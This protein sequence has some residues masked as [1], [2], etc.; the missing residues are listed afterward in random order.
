M[1][2]PQFQNLLLLSGNTDTVDDFALWYAL[3]LLNEKKRMGEARALQ[4]VR[5]I[6]ADLE[7]MRALCKRQIASLQEM[8]KQALIEEFETLNLP[9]IEV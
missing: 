5:Q 6:R 1:T 9:G 2:E 3:L 7:R 8:K 4:E